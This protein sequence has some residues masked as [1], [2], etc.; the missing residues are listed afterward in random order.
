MKKVYKDSNLNRH[1]ELNLK[2]ENVS[3]MNILIA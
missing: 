2:S 3:E 1:E